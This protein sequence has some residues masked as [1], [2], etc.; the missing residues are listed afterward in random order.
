M[1]KD[2]LTDQ[3]NKIENSDMQNGQ[4]V[5]MRVLRHFSR[6]RII[7]N[8]WMFIYKKNSVLFGHLISSVGHWAA[9]CSGIHIN[10]GTDDRKA[11]MDM[12]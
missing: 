9:P 6:E 1:R 3:R 7:W 5:L 12:K 2:K 10:V 4:F 8:S 11:P